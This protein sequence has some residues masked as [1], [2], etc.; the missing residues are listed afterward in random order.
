MLT[1]GG[2][3]LLSIVLNIDRIYQENQVSFVEKRFSELIAYGVFFFLVIATIRPE[4]M[5]PSR[6]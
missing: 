1:F 3:A 6:A 5:R 4:E 2:V